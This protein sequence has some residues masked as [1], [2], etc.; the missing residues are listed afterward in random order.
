MNKMIINENEIIDFIFDTLYSSKINLEKLNNGKY[1]HNTNY[2]NAPL[3]CKYGILSLLEL[4]KLGIRN[5]F[6]E[7]LEKMN[8]VESHING[9]DGVSLAVLGLTDLYSSEDEYNPL[10]SSVVD[11]IISNNI[12][13]H[14]NT[15]HYGNEFICYDNIDLEN[16]LSLDF[17]ILEYIGLNDKI[18]ISGDRLIDMYNNLLQCAINLNNIKSGMLLREM[19]F[20]NSFSVDIDKFSQSSCLILK[21]ELTNQK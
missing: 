15:I 21:K 16:I 17:R 4:N 1:H 3:V 8:D 18:C 14:R 9:N 20:N 11:F 12:R 10:D 2:K 13:A 5:D 19:S 7:L 6:S